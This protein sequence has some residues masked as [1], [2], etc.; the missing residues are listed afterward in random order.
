MK[1]QDFW[2]VISQ[3]DQLKTGQVLQRTI[4]GEWLAIFRGKNGQ[5]V[6]MRDRCLHRH[7][8]LSTGHV[9]QGQLHCPY[10]GWAYDSEGQVMAVPAEGEGFQPR[11]CRAK[12]Y[13]TCERDGYIYV[14]LANTPAESFSPFAMPYYDQPG[15]ETVRVINR[16][17]NTVTNCVENFID[18]P[19]TVSV[20][21]GIFRSPRQQQLNMQVFRSSGSV[22]VEYRNETT[23]LGW[24]QRFLNRQGKEVR[25]TDTFH[26]PNIT[27]VHYDISPRRQLFITS[28]SIPET[29]N[30][31]LVYT[32]VTYNYGLWN[33]L[34]RP[35]VRWTAQRIIRQDIEILSIQG[36]TLQKYGEQFAHTPA[37]T[38]HVFVESIRK[39][40]AAGKDPR[41]APDRSATVKF[42]V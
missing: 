26:M 32:D 36:E 11:S 23:N 30:S 8:R 19:H 35:F 34:A 21:P 12:T 42:W 4:L 38:V 7:S 25:H 20:H 31:T 6:A 22:L 5:P 15:W 41:L 9:N 39:A 14:R 28:Q 18:V 10:H 37:D 27:S 29:D 40:I 24:W 17:R 2:Y 3:S 1:F 16:F 33:T 13:S